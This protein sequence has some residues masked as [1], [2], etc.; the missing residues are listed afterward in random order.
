MVAEVA[1]AGDGRVIMNRTEE[2]AAVVIENIFRHATGSVDI[3][4]GHLYDKVY[5][6]LE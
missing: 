3:L 5:G 4:T 6:T 2:Y 1:A